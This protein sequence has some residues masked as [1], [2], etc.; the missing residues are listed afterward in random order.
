L[1]GSLSLADL[2]RQVNPIVPGWIN[3]Y[4]RFY[5]TKL[6]EGVRFSV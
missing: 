5:P 4:G 2:A 3:Y 1:Q 6:L